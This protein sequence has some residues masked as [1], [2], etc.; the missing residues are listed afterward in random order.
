MDFSPV[1]EKESQKEIEDLPVREEKFHFSLNL[2]YKSWIK[3]ASS[4]IS[5]FRSKDQ[6][7]FVVLHGEEYNLEED[8]ERLRKDFE[9]CIW[10]TYRNGFDPLAGGLD[11]DAGWGCM[12]RS[13]QMILAE[14]LKRHLLTRGEKKKF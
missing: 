5:Y 7:K 3:S 14:V 8:E 10:L 11:N 6:E 2:Q 9:S 4:A 13:G 1:G 12:V